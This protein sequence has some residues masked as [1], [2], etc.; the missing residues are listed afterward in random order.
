[1]WVRSV[2]SKTNN[3]PLP[4]AVDERTIYRI[5]GMISLANSIVRTQKDN[6]FMWGQHYRGNERTCHAHRTPDDPASEVSISRWHVD[7]GDIHTIQ[8]NNKSRE[9]KRIFSKHKTRQLIQVIWSCNPQ[10]SLQHMWHNTNHDLTY[11]QQHNHQVYESSFIRSTK[12]TNTE[13]KNV[14][15]R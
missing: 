12:Y 10:A 1:M 7:T 13:G 11:K 3:I 5:H 8:K 6:G 14:T 2:H 15:G 9:K 4:G